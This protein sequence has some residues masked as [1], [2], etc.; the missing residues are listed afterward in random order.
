M[1]ISER[2]LDHNV[3]LENIFISCAITSYEPVRPIFPKTTS[4]EGTFIGPRRDIN[5]CIITNVIGG[6]ITWV[7]ELR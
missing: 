6:V 7:S 1:H 4:T 2:P 3:E 5:C